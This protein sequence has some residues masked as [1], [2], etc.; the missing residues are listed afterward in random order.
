VPEI[1]TYPALQEALGSHDLLGEILGR[2][3]EGVAIALAP[4]GQ[5]VYSNPQAQR[6][7]PNEEAPTH[8]DKYRVP[9]GLKADGHIYRSHEWPLA[10]SILQGE[11]VSDEDIVF[12]RA[13]DTRLLLRVS[14][15]PLRNAANEIVAAIVL[16]SDITDQKHA[17]DVEHTLSPETEATRHDLKTLSSSLGTLQ[18]Q[19]ETIARQADKGDFS[20]E[21]AKPRLDK[22]EER[23]SDL[24]AVL[25]GILHK[26]DIN[27]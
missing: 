14:S 5:V 13:D 26:T 16:L 23:L 7:L 25:N 1:R 12:V 19:I 24:L 10:R 22:V 15:W 3:P 11:V 2:L 4:S 9:F 8:V 17:K 20:A 27:K 18:M 6:F 21:W